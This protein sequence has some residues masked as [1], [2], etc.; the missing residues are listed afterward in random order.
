MGCTPRAV[1]AVGLPAEPRQPVMRRRPTATAR[2][3]TPSGGSPAGVS[4]G[5][6]VRAV[7]QAHDDTGLVS[8]GLPGCRLLAS[9]WRRGWVSFQ[10]ASETIA[11][12]SV[13][14]VLEGSPSDAAVRGAFSF[15]S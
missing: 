7:Y 10:S 8:G 4:G 1:P 9:R 3:E 2:A 11:W 14:G 12:G 6:A 5:G 13:A 15:P